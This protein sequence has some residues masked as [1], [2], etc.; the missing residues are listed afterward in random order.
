MPN[1]LYEI[2]IV[3][4]ISTIKTTFY[5]GTC[6][7]VEEWFDGLGLKYIAVN[8]LLENVIIRSKVRSFR[9]KDVLI[10]KWY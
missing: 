4:D 2:E 10:N 3:E 8:I 1:N 7:Q 9:L 5:Y 6:E